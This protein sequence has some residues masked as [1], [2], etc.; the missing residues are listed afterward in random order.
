[1]N[2]HLK[3]K[4]RCSVDEMASA[5]ARCGVKFCV[6]RE[7]ND[8]K[9]KRNVNISQASSPSSKP[10]IKCIYCGG[11]HLSPKCRT[12]LSRKAVASSEVSYSVKNNGKEVGH[13][14]KLESS[15]FDNFQNYRGRGFG[16]SRNGDRGRVIE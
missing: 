6:S 5:E 12:N 4:E 13:D 2:V 16:S 10:E 1:M 14:R 9:R 3:P 7:H 8:R 11:T 15:K